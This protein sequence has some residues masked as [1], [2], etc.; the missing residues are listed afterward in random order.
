MAHDAVS[1][2]T[3]WEDGDDW[4]GGEYGK[5]PHPHKTL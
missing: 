3:V 4:F 5:A 2:R 1:D